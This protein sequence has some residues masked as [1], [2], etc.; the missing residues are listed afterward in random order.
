MSRGRRQFTCGRGSH[1]RRGVQTHTHAFALPLTR[2]RAHTRACTQR[3]R[4]KCAGPIQQQCEL[5]DSLLSIS[6]HAAEK[7]EFH[8]WSLRRVRIYICHDFQSS[9]T[10]SHGALLPESVCLIAVSLFDDCADSLSVFFSACMFD[11][12]LW[13]CRHTKS[14]CPPTPAFSHLSIMDSQSNLKQAELP[15]AKVMSRM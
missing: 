6:R 13:E 14:F 2:A 15:S 4:N 10:A 3:K 5:P 8:F 11:Q 9:L 7:E 1:G 12:L